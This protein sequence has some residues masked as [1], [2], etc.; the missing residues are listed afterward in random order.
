MFKMSSFCKPWG[1]GTEEL[2]SRAAIS[3]LGHSHLVFIDPGVKI[4]RAYYRDVLL[5]QHLLPVI[6]NLAQE[7]Y[8]IFQQDSAPAHRAGG[9][10]EML[11]R[12]TPDF[13]PHYG[14]QTA[15]I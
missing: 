3:R 6:R 8:F 14:L 10:I 4:I 7:G 9:T 1:T 12:D 11:R 15:K 13:L 5:A 2:C